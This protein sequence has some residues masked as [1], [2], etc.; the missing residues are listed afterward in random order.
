MIYLR[1]L[2]EQAIALRGLAEHAG[3]ADVVAQ[4]DAQ[5][6]SQAILCDPVPA[7][8]YWVPDRSQPEEIFRNEVADAMF[9]AM[10][11]AWEKA[12]KQKVQARSLLAS[13]VT[14]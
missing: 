8:A 1:L 9:R 12:T 4:L 2:P 11:D 14:E 6:R 7:L 13:E 5:G 10:T 3:L